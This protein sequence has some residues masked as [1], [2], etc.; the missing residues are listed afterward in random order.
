[1]LKPT[2]FVGGADGCKENLLSVVSHR[3]LEE[4]C[5]PAE[6]GLAVSHGDT[7]VLRMQ[8]FS[9]HCGFGHEGSLSET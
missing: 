6:D 9:L 2:L 4:F 7:V 3:V 5:L 8:L 1:M